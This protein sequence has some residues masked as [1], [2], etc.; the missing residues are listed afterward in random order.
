MHSNIYQISNT[1]ICPDE[2]AKP[3]TYYDN[4]GDFADYIGD[5]REGEERQW[6]I[7]DFG[8]IISPVFEK[9]EAEGVF[10]YKGKDA[11]REFKQA[12]CDELKRKATELT[13]ETIFQGFN[14]FD[15]HQM[16]N[17]THLDV[18]SRVD[19]DG[20][21]VAEPFGELFQW[22]DKHLE[23]GDCIYLGSIVDFYY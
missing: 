5:A 16:T 20:N 1:P 14:L 21:G 6:V 19:I 18:A 22:A 3:E 9:T 7:E 11:M 13:P 17:M 12:W 10:R 15:I 8:N 2:W 4:S 23:E